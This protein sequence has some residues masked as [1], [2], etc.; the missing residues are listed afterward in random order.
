MALTLEAILYYI[1]VLD[2]SVYFV[3]SHT[4]GKFHKKSKHHLLDKVP[5][6]KLF[7]LIYIGHVIWVGVSLHRLGIL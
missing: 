6:N 5:L 4:A 2:S 7:A 3:M 1:F